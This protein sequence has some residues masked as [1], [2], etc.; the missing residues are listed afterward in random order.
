M[1]YYVALL[2][3]TGLRLHVL[4]KDPVNL[5]DALTYSIRYE[6]LIA[7]LD[8]HPP[9]L[10]TL[11]PSSYVYDDKGRKKENVRSVEIHNDK[12]MDLESRGRKINKL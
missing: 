8:E 3:D 4:S 9:K 11:D 12:Q 5:E 10:L 1:D 2:G 7:G 6:A